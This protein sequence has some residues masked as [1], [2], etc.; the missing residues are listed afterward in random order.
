MQY[1][2]TFVVTLATLVGFYNYAPLDLVSF[3]VPETQ[4]GSTI[5]T[6]LGSDTLSGS[7][8]VINTNFS[9][10]NTDKLESGSSAT[11]LTITNASTTRI[12]CLGDCAFGATATSSFSSA[13]VL[14]LS[15]PLT[16]AN[17]GTGW[18][19]IQS[20]YIPFGNGGSAISTSTA[21][22][23]NNTYSRLT[24]TNA[25]T[26]NA[27]VSSL[28]SGRIPY[29]GASSTFFDTSSLVYD[30]TNVRL[31]IASS[32]PSYG[33]SIGSG[34]AIGVQEYAISTSTSIT[35]DARNGNQQLIQMGTAATTISFSNF[36]I[37]TTIRLVVCNP[38]SSAG[39][40]TWSGARYFGG[41]APT[42][43]TTANQ[44]DMYVVGSTAATSTGATTPII[45]LSQGGAGL[46]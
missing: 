16:V 38:G 29:I 17:G 13:G 1:I 40:I 14:T 45:W 8:S 23:F 37:G 28:T 19:A 20:S 9:N 22:A 43:I 33:L 42:Q 34:K 41:A 36:G 24:V 25:S 7:R 30:F 21:L 46:Q 31:G 35:V 26:T 39:A 6:I 44:C 12:S 4:F 18:A 3:N 15:A 11:A 2:L 10:L 27:S 32:T 5:T